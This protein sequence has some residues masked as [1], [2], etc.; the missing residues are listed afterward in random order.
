MIDASTEGIE[1]LV[2]SNRTYNALRRAGIST[3]KQL[4]ELPCEKLKDIRYL[5]DSCIAELFSKLYDK[6]L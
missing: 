6:C 2:L 5:G 4:F 1:L 3:I